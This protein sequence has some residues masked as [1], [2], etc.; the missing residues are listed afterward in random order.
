M[1]AIILAGGS[2]TRLRPLSAELPK[3]MVPFLGRP[4]LEHILLLLRR[5]GIGEAAITLH[6]LPEA[7]EDYFGDGSA[8]GMAL[9][10]FR[11]EEPL[12]T[13]GAVRAC[14][15]FWGDD[16]D[17][18]ALSG[19]ALC[20]F[21]LRGPWT[22]TGSIRPPPRC[23]STAPPRRWNTVWCAPMRTGGWCSSWK[24]PAGGRCSPIR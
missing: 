15:D 2:G 9:T 20:D 12:G 17:I 11:E 8:F 4:L 24:N 3:P 19:D 14:M 18:L 22:S 21:D 7:V 16:P 13:A 23:C 5:S 1:K 10:Y 6:Y